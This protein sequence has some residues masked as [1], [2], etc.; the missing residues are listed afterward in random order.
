M[1]PASNNYTHK[2][3]KWLFINA[4]LATFSLILA[5]MSSNKGNVYDYHHFG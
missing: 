4:F 1:A 3:P 2:H 5:V